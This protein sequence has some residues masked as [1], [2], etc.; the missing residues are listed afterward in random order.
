MLHFFV[1]DITMKIKYIG[2]EKT[3]SDYNNHKHENSEVLY[4][5]NGAGRVKTAL[6]VTELCEG[7]I[8]FIPPATYHTGPGGDCG[9]IY[10]IADNP[11][12]EKLRKP[13][14]IHDDER[15]SMKTYFENIY[16][17]NKRPDHDIAYKNV[18]D[19][20]CD[21]IFELLFSIQLTNEQDSDVNELRSVILRSFTD[22]DFSLGH[23][24]SKITYSVTY[25]RRRFNEIIGMSPC[26]YLNSMRIGYAK[27][28]IGQRKENDL[29]YAKIAQRSGFSDERYFS[30]VFKQYCDMTPSEYYKAIT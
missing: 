11:V 21:L 7:D 14:I 30:R 2:R 5:T 17:I 19:S 4:I 10:I 25:L 18:E 23:E 16:D 8:V 20:L 9:L 1:G 13:F 26:K 24:M 12:P 6:G 28:L 27:K 3:K 22:P 15:H 29:S